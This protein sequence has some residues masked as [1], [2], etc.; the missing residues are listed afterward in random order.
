MSIRRLELVSREI[1]QNSNFS[2]LNNLHLIL[3]ICLRGI[4]LRMLRKIRRCT[5][6]I[7][8]ITRIWGILGMVWDGEILWKV[9]SLRTPSWVDLR[10]GK[11]ITLPAVCIP[12]E[13]LQVHSIPMAIPILTILGCSIPT[14]ILLIIRGHTLI[15]TC[16][17]LHIYRIFQ[18]VLQLKFRVVLQRVSQISVKFLLHLRLKNHL[19]SLLPHHMLKK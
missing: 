17:H 14:A 12:W 16:L 3:L 9:G 1:L 5:Q 11:E 4:L 8:S 13:C 15:C 6:L 2:H 19:L 18:Q 7:M 10:K